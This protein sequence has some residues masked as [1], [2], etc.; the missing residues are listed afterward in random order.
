V[1]AKRKIVSYKEEIADV[2]QVLFRG[3]SGVGKMKRE[4]EG[5]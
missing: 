2:K 1:I 5:R 3:G 4:D